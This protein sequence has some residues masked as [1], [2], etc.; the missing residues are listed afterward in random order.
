MLTSHLNKNK[1]QLSKNH[2]KL[3]PPPPKKTGICLVTIMDSLS[4]SRWQNRKERQNWST[5]NRDMADKAKCSVDDGV[6]LWH[7]SN[8]KEL[9]IY[10]TTVYF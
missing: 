1:A 10:M 8:D 9:M 7:L 3:N 5:I 4:K 2:L 6:S